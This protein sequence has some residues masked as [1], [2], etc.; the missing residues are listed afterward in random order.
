MSAG[1]A[2]DESAEDRDQN[3]EHDEGLRPLERDE[4]DGIYV[5]N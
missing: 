4:N 3:A 1:A 2:R 5:G